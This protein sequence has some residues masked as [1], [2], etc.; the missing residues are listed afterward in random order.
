MLLRFQRRIEKL[1]Q[2]LGLGP[3]FRSESSTTTHETHML[4]TDRDEKFSLLIYS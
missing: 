4:L 2:E 3:G 1:W